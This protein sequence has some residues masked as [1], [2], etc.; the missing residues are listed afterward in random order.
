MRG[1][2]VKVIDEHLCVS[3]ICP[4]WQLLIFF[5]VY[6]K[7][8]NMFLCRERKMFHWECLQIGHVQNE[9]GTGYDYSTAVPPVHSKLSYFSDFLKVYHT[10][11]FEPIT[12]KLGKFTNFG[13]LFKVTGFNSQFN[14]FFNICTQSPSLVRSQH[15]E[16][17][18]KLK[19]A[20]LSSKFPSVVNCLELNY[21][22]FLHHVVLV[23]QYILCA[24]A[25]TLFPHNF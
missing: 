10:F 9:Q 2:R 22:G 8:D 15:R 23:E 17:P 24:N 3:H 1:F 7:P 25:S 12:L 4:E 5:L 21:W 16:F 6:F 11:A 20:L 13:M 18:G 19:S 14:R